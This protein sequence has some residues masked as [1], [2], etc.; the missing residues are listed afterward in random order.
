MSSPVRK[1]DY[2]TDKETSLSPAS[3]NCQLNIISVF[4]VKKVS[5]TMSGESTFI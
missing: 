5:S 2:G 3:C 4:R 1:P